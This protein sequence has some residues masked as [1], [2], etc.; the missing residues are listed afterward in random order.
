MIQ[1]YPF[2]SLCVFAIDVLV[3]Y[4]LAAYGGRRTGIDA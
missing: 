1:A 2:W 4:A 3:I